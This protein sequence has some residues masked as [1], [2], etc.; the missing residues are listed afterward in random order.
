M[1][2][3]K[4]TFWVVQFRFAR[5]G[6]WVNMFVSISRDRNWTILG[7]LEARALSRS[8]WRRYR[9]N[10]TV[11]CIKVR[12]VPVTDLDHGGDGQ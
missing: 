4:D 12:V 6:E 9:R 1:T 11:R 8:D 10:G 2:A 7:Y 3:K 5:D